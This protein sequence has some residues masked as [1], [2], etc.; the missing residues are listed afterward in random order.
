MNIA[1]RTYSPLWLYT[2]KGYGIVM[3][4]KGPHNDI[5]TAIES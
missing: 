4:Q 1:Q 2:L 5:T 3:S